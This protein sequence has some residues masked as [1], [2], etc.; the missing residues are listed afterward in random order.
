MEPKGNGLLHG[1]D[2]AQE[3]LRPTEGMEKEPTAS[4]DQGD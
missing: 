4:R 1:I 2:F 3:S